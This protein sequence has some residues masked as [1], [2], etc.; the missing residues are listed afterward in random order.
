MNL[1]PD[2]QKTID[3]FSDLASRRALACTSSRF[4]AAAKKDESYKDYIKR[5]GGALST[6]DGVFAKWLAGEPA[7]E[8]GYYRLM[9][10]K[11]REGMFARGRKGP[12]NPSEDEPPCHRHEQWRVDPYVHSPDGRLLLFSHPSKGDVVL[13]VTTPKGQKLVAVYAKAARMDR[14]AK[15]LLGASK[16]VQ[17]LVHKDSRL[18]PWDPR[19]G[20]HGTPLP[21]LVGMALEPFGE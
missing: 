13:G 20:V 9:F 17:P 15:A 3:G 1:P 16:A 4:H 14:Y 19:L 21:S 8:E 6:R 2:L 18:S 7:F 5:F 11:G 12:R 10:A